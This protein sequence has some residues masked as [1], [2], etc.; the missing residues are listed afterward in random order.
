[1]SGGLLDGGSLS[2]DGAALRRHIE[3]R[4]D[5]LALPT[6]AALGDAGCERLAELASAFSRAVVEAGL[7][8]PG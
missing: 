1:M 2:T 3:D 5:R 7:L 6:Y 4:T 8:K